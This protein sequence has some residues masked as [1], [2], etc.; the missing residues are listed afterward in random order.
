[1]SA[2]GREGWPD[3]VK[4][5][6]IIL[7]VLWHVVVK[8]S[9]DLPWSGAGGI[10]QLWTL[11][12]A[13]LL[14]LRMPLFFLVSGMFA[15]GAVLAPERSRLADRALRLG[16]LYALWVVIQTFALAAAGPEFDTARATDPGGLLRNL[17]ISPTN[18]W[19][20]LALA[21][22]L[23]L[24]RLTRGV[25]TAV[26]LPVAFVVSAS[27]AAGILP[28]GGNL[29]Q[30]GQNVFFFL[31]G[32]RLR[33]AVRRLAEHRPGWR[34][35][36]VLAGV[37][38]AGL[39]LVRLLGAAQWFGVWTLLSILAVAAG[40]GICALIDRW[41]PAAAPLRWIGRR[42][43]PIYVIHMIPLALADRMLRGV[44]DWVFSGPMLAVLEPLLVVAVVIAVSLGV[45]A[46][47]MRV[48]ARWL[49]DPLVRRPVRTG[50]PRQSR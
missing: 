46:L 14:P 36:V 15:A 20:L 39:L 12:S 33:A 40:V 2:R 37:Y 6:C 10:P 4:G 1:M 32:L 19:Y 28:D 26:L 29:W 42:T 8:H 38:V 17:T 21:L 18:L 24:G 47:L 35:A 16:L 49:F 22:Y 5:V 11:V 27:A 44:D 9:S 48:G 13:Q 45:H 30:V 43:L 50:S 3:V 7:V 41:E 25:P 31:A 34:I 23:V